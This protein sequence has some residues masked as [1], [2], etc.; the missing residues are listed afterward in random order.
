M[1]R[2]YLKT[3]LR[4]FSKNRFFTV[5]NVFCL[6]LGM[7]I[8][9]IFVALLS[10]LFRFDDFHPN[11]E[12]IYRIT[13]Q[14]HDNEQNP[15][16]ASA[17]VALVQKLRQEFTGIETVVPIEASIWTEAEYLEKKVRVE[18]YFTSPEFLKVFNFPLVKGNAATAL[19]N[20][21]S[22]LI[23]ESE[24]HNIFG[25]ADP[26]GEILTIS[27]VGEFMVTGIL[28]DRPKNSHLRFD[29]LASHSTLASF[30]GTAFM[31]SEESW[32]KFMDSYVYLVLPPNSDASNVQ[33]YLNKVAQDKYR[34]SQKFKASFELQPM[35]KIVPG[36]SL[37]NPIGSQWDLL[38]LILIGSTTMIILIPACAN[39]INLS[40]SQSL[41]RMKEIGVRKV[42]GGQRKQIFFQ[43]VLEAVVTML[44]ALV[45]SF[46]MFQAI[47][48][49]FLEVVGS[50]SVMDLSP[51]FLT[52][53][54]FILFAMLVGFIAGISPAIYFS[55]VNPVKALKGKPEQA[56]RGFRFP[57]RKVMITA[58]FI[59]SL[60][61]IMSVVIMVQQYRY[62]VGYD[63]GFEQKN[64]LDIELRNIDP[65]IFRNEFS[66]LAPIERISM[67]S[68]VLGLKNRG[69]NY[70]RT[71]D[72]PDSIESA[73]MSIDE[74]FFENMKLQM[75]AGRTFSEN[76]SENAQGII[77]NEE[78]VKKLG[79]AGT[80]AAIGEAVVLPSG[81][82][83]RIIGVM[84]NFHY[85]G[86]FEPI[87][88]LYFE[89][90]P[91]Q[92]RYANV[93]MIS[94]PGE[95]EIAA[96]ESLWKKIGGVDK[97]PWSYFTEEI[98]EAYSY[99]F[100]VIE[101]W[102]YLGLLAITVSC[103]GL[104]GTVVFTI[105]NRVKEVSIRKV[106]GASNPSLVYLLS[107]D[108]ILMMVIASVITIPTVYFAFSDWLLPSI[109]HYSK[110][111]GVS[112][113][114]IS[115]AIMMTLGLTT[116]FSQTL[117]AAN[118]NPVD[119]LKVE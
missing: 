67:S 82:A 64:I 35:D 23:T 2:N 106:V 96:M 31:E 32:T 43:F 99:Y 44:I 103:V 93:K 12:R 17:P 56:K 27:G 33:G 4:N 50:S 20:P 60:G 22:I 25:S 109:Q 86:L 1:F 10:F 6:A 9:L 85:A 92:F 39:Y 68:H 100:E 13:T 105:R 69:G 3:A 59:L 65:K 63:F 48:N 36:P 84:N 49:E 5:L 53:V 38:S 30:K 94:A 90:D 54:N 107:K 46:F 11:S 58:Q 51:T 75:V 78:L 101:I 97:L 57:V 19:I 119:N 45:L 112:E 98:A 89:Y 42:M 113:I 37:S 47:R 108:F 26:M 72:K 111:I 16:Y 70:L 15:V 115:L 61:F 95:S 87:G 8:S 66:S 102:G 52:I 80:H 18:G 104:L 55:K 77:V 76:V 62:S 117:K 110:T 79:L 7:S 71:V 83:V 91:E 73:G 41:K 118:T 81:K 40:I 114:G 21:N 29:V 28:K 88:C 34:T 74:N 116:I 14:V 24:A